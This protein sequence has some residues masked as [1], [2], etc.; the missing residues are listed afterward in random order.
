MDK[1]M[2]KA[3]ANWLARVD[4]DIATAEQMLHAGRYIYVIFMS[5]MALEKALKAVVTE[6][7]QKLPLTEGKEEQHVETTRPSLRSWR[8][9][10]GHWTGVI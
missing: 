4:Y 6:E 2:L 8:P 9:S 1:R 5:H 7:T 10:S 3:T